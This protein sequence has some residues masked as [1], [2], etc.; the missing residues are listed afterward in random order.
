MPRITQIF[1]EFRADW[2]DK[3]RIIRSTKKNSLLKK[4]QKSILII[5]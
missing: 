2:F 3:I 5:L 1:H 4:S